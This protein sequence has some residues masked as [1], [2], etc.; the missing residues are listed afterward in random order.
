MLQKRDCRPQHRLRRQVCSAVEVFHPA[1]VHSA[2]SEQFT[3]ESL[4]AIRFQRSSATAQGRWSRHDDHADG[5][6]A[7]AHV[8]GA[9]AAGLPA[10]LLID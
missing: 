3:L 5:V 9:A 6:V 7:V 10:T 1:T 2:L 4:V 8:A